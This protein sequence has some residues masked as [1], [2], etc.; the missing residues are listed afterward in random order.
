M[1]FHSPLSADSA[2]A[3]REIVQTAESTQ[4][5]Q[6]QEAPNKNEDQIRHTQRHLLRTGLRNSR[7]SSTRRP[8][9]AKT[10]SIEQT[11]SFVQYSIRFPQ[12]IKSSSRSTRTSIPPH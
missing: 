9:P 6:S 7:G 2:R 1:S 5:A 10:I 4:A 3:A 11:Y 12:L 8:L